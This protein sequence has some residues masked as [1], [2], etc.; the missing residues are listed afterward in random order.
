MVS[1]SYTITVIMDNFWQC[2][3][4]IMQGQPPTTYFLW[5]ECPFPEWKCWAG[6][7]ES[8]GEHPQAATP[9]LC[10]LASSSAFCVVAICHAQCCPF[11]QQFASAR[12]WD[13]KAW[14]IRLNLSRVQYEACAHF[15]VPSV[16]ITKCIGFRQVATQMVSTCQIRPQPRTQ[17]YPCKECLPGTQFDDWVRISTVQLLA[18]WLLWEDTSWRTWY[19][20]HRLLAATSRTFLCGTDSFQ[21]C[22]AYAVQYGVISN[23]FGKQA[24]WF[25]WFLCAPSGFWRCDWWQFFCRWGIT[26]H[27]ILRKFLHKSSSSPSWGSYYNWAYC[28]SWY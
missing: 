14:A 7:L 5:R 3:E 25:R 2:L 23:S 26:S 10:L 13:V 11:P 28:H 1:A 19:F 4:V 12:G 27:G 17:S 15:C 24:W 6:D 9:C 22:T 8:V 21:S 16:C 20:W 18:W